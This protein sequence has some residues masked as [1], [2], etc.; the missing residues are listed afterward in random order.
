MNA[1]PG[2]PVASTMTSMRDRSAGLRVAGDKRR[3][4]LVRIV[5]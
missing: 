2:T 5:E 1:G 3:A 4:P